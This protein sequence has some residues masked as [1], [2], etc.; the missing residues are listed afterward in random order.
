MRAEVRVL[1]KGGTPFS[2]MPRTSPEADGDGGREF[3][4]QDLHQGVRLPWKEF[5]SPRG[6]GLGQWLERGAAS[7][8]CTQIGVWVVWGRMGSLGRPPPAGERPQF[9]SSADSPGPSQAAA[10]V[11]KQDEVQCWEV[12]VKRGPV[13]QAQTSGSSPAPG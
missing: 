9:R 4:I 10:T 11:Q 8:N 2:L 7:P 5:Q 6:D 3:Q 12:G 1:G 13:T